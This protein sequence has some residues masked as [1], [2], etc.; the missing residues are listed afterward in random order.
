MKIALLLHGLTR[1]YDITYPFI[2]KNIIDKFDT[3]VFISCWENKVEEEN[4]NK[5]ENLPLQ[6]LLDLYKP[7]NFD[8]EVYDNEREQ[9][10]FCDEYSKYF[11][12]IETHY[13]NVWTRLFAFYYKVWKANE[14]K[15]EY[16][17]EKNFKYDVVLK[18]RTDIF[19]KDVLTQNLLNEIKNNNSVYIPYGHGGCINDLLYFANSDLMDKISKLYNNL[20]NISKKVAPDPSYEKHL[21]VWLDTENINTNHFNI[22]WQYVTF[23]PDFKIRTLNR[24]N[25][26]NINI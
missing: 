25:I 3:D 12:H 23:R 19:F 24:N 11:P 10:F 18:L 7:T 5:G 21:K 22:D 4:I 8:F 16:E 2:K 15:K 13:K 17:K 9:S 20:K 14:L 26:L 6:G 1:R